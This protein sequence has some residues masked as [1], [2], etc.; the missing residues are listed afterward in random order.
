MEQTAAVKNAI[1]VGYIRLARCEEARKVLN[2]ALTLAEKDS[3]QACILN[4]LANVRL[5]IEEDFIQ[6]RIAMKY[7]QAIKKESDPQNRLIIKMNKICYGPYAYLDKED[8]IRY[9][10]NEFERLLEEEEKLFGSNQIVWI[11]GYLTLSAFLTDDDLQGENEIQWINKA[12]EMNQK[13]YQYKAVDIII[14]SELAGCYYYLAE[15]EKAL[16]CADKWIELSEDFLAEED[17]IMFVAGYYDKA[18]ILIKE[19]QYEEAIKCINTLLGKEGVHIEKRAIAWF[20]LGE[21]YYEKEGQIK[22][23]EMALKG[24]D[25]FRQYKDENGCGEGEWEIE[26]IIKM[27]RNGNYD[28]GNLEYLPWLQEQLE[29]QA[30]K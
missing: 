24:Y 17:D 15:Y 2:Q 14:Y 7:D 13:N 8:P 9:V 3:E 16:E 6:N 4:N 28:E 27:Y 5:V 19:K 23:E 26:E 11:Y 18:S 10:I 20:K 30:Q 12:M 1:G 22:A 25:V 21:I 29:K